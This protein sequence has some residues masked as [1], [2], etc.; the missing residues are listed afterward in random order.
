MFKSLK[1]PILTRVI[2]LNP[3]R[4]GGLSRNDRISCL[5]KIAEGLS[6]LNKDQFKYRN[7]ITGDPR[8]KI[9]AEYHVGMVYEHIS[10]ILKIV[11]DNRMEYDEDGGKRAFGHLITGKSHISK[12]AARTVA[13][14]AVK[15]MENFFPEYEKGFGNPLRSYFG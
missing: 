1:K 10:R 8:M 6:V 7:A 4:F 3:E 2:P 12:Y 5:E 15:Y 13:S 9:D 14:D 11:A